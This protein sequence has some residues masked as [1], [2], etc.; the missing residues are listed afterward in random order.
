M[1]PVTVSDNTQWF[2]ADSIHLTDLCEYH[3]YFEKTTVLSLTNNKVTRICKSL[4]D[5]MTNDTESTLNQRGHIWLSG[6]PFH[7]DCEMTW[8][9]DWLNTFTISSG[10]HIVADYRNLTCQTGS[11]KGTPIYELNE[12]LMG[13]FPS[14]WRTWHKVVVGIGAGITV[15]IIVILIAT[16]RSREMKFLLYYHLKLNTLADDDKNETLDNVR[17]D[18]FF[19]FW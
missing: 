17:Y 8:M 7:C 3:D 11:M 10:E 6:N 13:C 15:I 5:K 19:C 2:L 14:K 1:L 12:V 16:K 4:V 18:A 9:T